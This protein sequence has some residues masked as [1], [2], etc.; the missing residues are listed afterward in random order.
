MRTPNIAVFLKKKFCD[1][2]SK[3]MGGGYTNAVASG[4]GGIY[5]AMAARE[6]PEN[7]DVLIISLVTCS[8][9]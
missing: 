6:I 9:L 7:S 3:F 8:E 1:E 5:V 4:T 2:F